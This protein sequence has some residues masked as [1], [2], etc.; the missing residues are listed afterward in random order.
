[1]SYLDEHNRHTVY[2]QKLATE[3]LNSNQYP[4]LREAYLAARRIL[5]EAENITSIVHLNK[6]TSAINKAVQD[7][8]VKPWATTAAELSSF[9]VYEAGFYAS[10]LAKNNDVKLSVPAPEK[11]QRY[12]DKSLLSLQSGNRVTAGLWGDLVTQ[13]KNSVMATFDNAVRAGYADGETVQQMVKRM[14]TATDGFLKSELESLVRTGVQ[15]YA[16]QARQAMAAD[17]KNVIAREVPIV[18]FDNRTSLTC[19]GHASKYGVKGWPAGESPIG[20]APYH[21]NCRTTIAYLVKGQEELEGMRT[22]VSGKKGEEARKAF[23][24]RKQNMKDYRESLE[25]NTNVK[26]KYRGRKDLDKFDVKQINAATPVD[27]WLKSQPT[28]YVES[29]LGKGRAELFLKGDLKLS[30]FTDM[31][32]DPFTL[33]QLRAAD[34]SAGL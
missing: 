30:K 33:E 4:S 29:L 23:E 1:M 12:V 32:G 17:N 14:R 18:T 21:W 6:I 16:V 3:L 5:L 25:L 8:T 9:A 22:A 2:V 28:W 10:L 20:Y 7:A 11:I 13:N 15:H 27:N 34:T 24:N 26:V 31:T 19:L